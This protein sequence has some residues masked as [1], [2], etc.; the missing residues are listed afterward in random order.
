M[1][2]IPGPRRAVRRKTWDLFFSWARDP[3]VFD[4]VEMHVTAGAEVASSLR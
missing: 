2:A 3:A 4:I 1:A